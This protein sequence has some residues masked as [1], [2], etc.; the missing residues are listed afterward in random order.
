MYANAELGSLEFSGT[1]SGSPN[2]AKSYEYYL[3]AANNNHPK[4]CF[5]VAELI[6]SNRVNVDNSMKVMWEYLNKAIKLGSIAAINTMGNCYRLGNNPD[7]IIDINK[8]LEY[9]I[10][11]S[12]YGY[13][14]AYNN[15]G[16]IYEQKNDI[17]NAIK[18]FKL[19]KIV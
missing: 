5:M 16:L 10:S 1:I 9:Y 6:L 12:E 3:N 15:I 2:Y 7:N 11:A 8:A 19:R 14:Y 13:V 4:A 18:Y 17:Q